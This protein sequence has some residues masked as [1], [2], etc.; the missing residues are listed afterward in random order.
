MKKLFSRICVFGCLAP[1]V[2]FVLHLLISM[3]VYVFSGSM[4][5]PLG[6]DIDRMF[7]AGALSIG[8][9]FISFV[10]YET[11]WVK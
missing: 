5:N 8:M 10:A 4:F 3:F 2:F 11:L 6:M 1:T 7:V 9:V